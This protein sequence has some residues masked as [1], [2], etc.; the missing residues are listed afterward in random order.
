MQELWFVAV[1]LLTIALGFLIA[2]Q[3]YRGYQRNNAQTLLYVAIGFVLISI[4]GVL[5]GLLVEVSGFSLV[6]AGFVASLLVT[7]G[8]LSILYALYAPNP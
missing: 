7:A 5:E 1:K 8:M 2:Y 4:G 6:E 3:A